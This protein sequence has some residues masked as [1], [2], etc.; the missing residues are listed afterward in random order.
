[1][2][3]DKGDIKCSFHILQYHKLRNWADVCRIIVILLWIVPTF[4]DNIIKLLNILPF[5]HYYI[6]DILPEN[7]FLHFCETGSRDF[8]HPNEWK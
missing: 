6:T 5:E 8:M 1:M 2:Q 7:I 4:L 3:K